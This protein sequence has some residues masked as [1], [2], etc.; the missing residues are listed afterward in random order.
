L[1]VAVCAAA[2]PLA[3][4]DEVEDAVL[5]LLELLELHAAAP[6][7]TAAASAAAARARL[8]LRIDVS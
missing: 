1:T 5:E 8:L 7:A 3:L 2:E 4:D 6:V